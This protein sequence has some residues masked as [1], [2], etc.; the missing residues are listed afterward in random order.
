MGFAPDV[1]AFAF[2]FLRSRLN[3]WGTERGIIV[4]YINGKTHHREGR[5]PPRPLWEAPRLQRADYLVSRFAGYVALVG[6]VVG[7]FLIFA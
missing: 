4:S 6:V 1:H 5:A 2:D 7:L 3:M